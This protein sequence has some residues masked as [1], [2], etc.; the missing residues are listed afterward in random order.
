MPSTPPP[1]DKST[2]KT[3]FHEFEADLFIYSLG[4]VIVLKPYIKTFVVNFYA[5]LS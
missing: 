2:T 4:K 5:L 3:T 1:T